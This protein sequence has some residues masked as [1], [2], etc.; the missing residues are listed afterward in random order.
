MSIIPCFSQI[1]RERLEEIDDP[2]L[3]NNNKNYIPKKIASKLNAK[4]LKSIENK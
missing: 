4:N 1:T 3:C 2:G